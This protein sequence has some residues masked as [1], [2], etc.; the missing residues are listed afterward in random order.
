MCHEAASIFLRPQVDIQRVDLVDVLLF[1]PCVIAREVPC[2]L[3]LCYSG[4]DQQGDQC[5]L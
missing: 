3:I 1:A 4:V 2:L 5:R